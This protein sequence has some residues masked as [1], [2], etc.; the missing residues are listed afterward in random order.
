M[1]NQTLERQ[2]NLVINLL[3]TLPKRMYDELEKRDGIKKESHIEKLKSEMDSFR[4]NKKINKFMY[5]FQGNQV[6]SNHG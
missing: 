1:S 6:D 3:E 5:G 4:K 2:L